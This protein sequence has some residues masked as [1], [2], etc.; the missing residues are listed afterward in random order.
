MWGE[1]KCGKV[2]CHKTINNLQERW[3][4]QIFVENLVFLKGMVLERQD[5]LGNKARTV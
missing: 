4:K 1:G 3:Q 2:S 5:R